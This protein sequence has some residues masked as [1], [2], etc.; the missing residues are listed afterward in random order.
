MLTGLE[1]TVSVGDRSTLK[2][3]T[4]G[5]LT[6]ASGFEILVYT[7]AAFAGGTSPTRTLTASAPVPANGL[8]QAVMPADLFAAAGRHIVRAA[9]TWADGEILGAPVELQVLRSK[10]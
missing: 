7:E 3:D 1:Y 8:I 6:G 5:D 9:V 4:K 10:D 2:V